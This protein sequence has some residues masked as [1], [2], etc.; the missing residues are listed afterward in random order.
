MSHKFGT[1]LKC[2]VSFEWHRLPGNLSAAGS[3]WRH[4]KWVETAQM[5]QT[6]TLLLP[7]GPLATLTHTH[8]QTCTQTHTQLDKSRT[9]KALTACLLL[10]RLLFH[11]SMENGGRLVDSTLTNQILSING[12]WFLQHTL[13]L[14]LKL[15]KQAVNLHLKGGHGKNVNTKNTL[16]ALLGINK[17]ILNWA[18]NNRI[19]PCSLS[20]IHIQDATYFL[21]HLL[22][23]LW[24]WWRNNDD[25]EKSNIFKTFNGMC[26]PYIF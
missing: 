14:V 1:H 3:E 17:L 24:I 22:T 12:F 15:G 5:V 6:Q 19:P 23:L 26:T 9:H 18:E 20:P 13:C 4:R 11:Y 7:A 21:F 10:R 2:Q 8:T 16:F 25:T